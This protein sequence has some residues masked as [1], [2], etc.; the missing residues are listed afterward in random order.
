VSQRSPVALVVL[1]VLLPVALTFAP[2]FAHAQVPAARAKAIVTVVDQSGGFI[3]GATVTIVGLESATKVAPV[4]PAKTDE[5]GIATFNNLPLGR[6]SIQGEFSGFQL[7]LV[8]DVRLKAGENKHIVILPLK[9]MSESVTVAQDSLQAASSRPTL[10]TALTRE[11]IDALSDDPDELQRQINDLAGPNATIRVDSFEGSQL[12]PKAQIKSI[13][14]TRDQ[15]AAENHFIGGLF[16]DIVT[17]PGIGKIRGNGNINYNGSQLNSH[18]AFV[19]EKPS[20]QNRSVGFGMGGTIVPQKSDFSINFNGQDSYTQPNTFIY[21]AQG[22]Q[23]ETLSIH[24]PRRQASVSAT[25]NYAITKDQTIR[26]SAFVGGNGQDNLGIAG[27][28][29]SDRAYSQRA[30]NRQVNFQEVG[31]IGRRLFLNTRG[32]FLYNHNWANSLTE[33][34]TIV[35][36]DAQTRGGAQRRGGSVSKTLSLQSDL[37]YIRGIN[38][39]RA[40][41]QFD[42]TWYDA[43]DDSNYLGTYTFTSLE[44]FAAGQPTFFT[45]RIGDPTIAYSNM[46]A[47]MYLQDD[48]RVSKTLTLS[49][50][51]RYEVQTHVTDYNGFGPRFGATWSPFKSGKT[52]IRGG[53]GIFYDWLGVGTYA[54]TIRVD[55][56]HQRD[57]TITNPTYPDPGN[58]GNITATNRYLIASNY[59]MPRSLGV[60]VGVDRT[61]TPRIRVSGGYTFT[62]GTKVARGDNLNA[63]IDGVRP[64][65]LFLNVIET[66]SDGAYRSH[67]AY[68]SSSFSLVSGPAAQQPRFNW[69]RLSFNGSY[70]A[71]HYRNNTDGA[72]AVP[73][74]G[75]LATEWGPNGRGTHFVS[76]S[77][78]SGVVKNMN[79]N[80][81]FN[82]SSG[83][84]YNIT[85][86]FDNNGDLM[87]N[88]R[89]AGVSRNS[90]QIPVWNVGLRA[91]LNY[92]FTFGKTASSAPP[93]IMIT[94]EGGGRLSVAQAPTS[95]A[96]RYRVSINVNANNLTNRNNYGGYVGNL[97]NLQGFGKPTT[98]GEPRRINISMSFGF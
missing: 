55:G 70:S 86:G 71:S 43:N 78:N 33:A 17:Q 83:G 89:P 49:P 87:F 25:M 16:I 46:Q 63:P 29:L 67:E 2:A 7:G 1:F 8:R 41:I 9:Q 74:S 6:Y 32:R 24:V 69:K 18:T 61:I 57:L 54:Q 80:V 58:V 96:G 42:G 85:T 23:T 77:I 11:Q 21:T 60:N 98:S 51:I 15:Y 56:F 65:P 39:W 27:N 97:S 22:Q 47:G 52:T 34:Q 66:V 40:G 84:Y 4:A 76:M 28:N 62:R 75:T 68:V 5:K 14:I 59:V 50:G 88:D 26:V 31:P 12:P 20:E 79:V 81:G 3:P 94:S 30:R 13:H 44:A 35:I 10:G 48:I 91:G 82:T 37:D 93:G 38:S 92:T 72:F 73:A 36:N 19:P 90:A 95:T 53:G 45:K 64:D